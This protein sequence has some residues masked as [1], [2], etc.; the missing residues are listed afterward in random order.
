MKYIELLTI[1]QVTNLVN[2]IGV[3]RAYRIL[4]H[5]PTNFINRVLNKLIK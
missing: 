2:R 5:K 4:N 1:Q 3:E